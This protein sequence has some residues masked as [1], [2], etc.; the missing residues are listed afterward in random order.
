MDGGLYDTMGWW[1]TSGR[2]G[3]VCDGVVGRGERV[4]RVRVVRKGVG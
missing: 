3:R 4:V 2:E 1:E